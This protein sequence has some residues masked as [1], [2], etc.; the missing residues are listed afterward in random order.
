MANLHQIEAYQN[1]LSSEDCQ[2]L[3]QLI[4]EF[5]EQE[6]HIFMKRHK[7]SH[8]ISTDIYIDF[9]NMLEE[10]QD[11]FFERVNPILLP[12][13]DKM[14]VAYKQSHPFL[15]DISPWQLH[16]WYNLQYY[17]EGQGYSA[18]HCEHDSNYIDK[19][20]DGSR[21]RVLVW[22]IYLN[23]AECGT[24]FPEQRL[25]ITPE[26]GL[27]VLWPSYWTHPH[28]GVTPNIGDK[29]IATGSFNFYDPTKELQKVNSRTIFLDMEDKTIQ[30]QN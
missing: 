18:L 22:M 8:K 10:V 15:N 28:Q 13:L 20:S 17:S 1:A 4:D 19:G 30:N 21:D 9:A 29:Y 14:T 11:P 2:S 23:N 25:T 27:G 26:E 5:K 3:I 12:A 6:S 16:P 7:G 24:N